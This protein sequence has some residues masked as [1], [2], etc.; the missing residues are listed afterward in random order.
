M[1]IGDKPPVGQSDIVRARARA[2]VAAAT[3]RAGSSAIQ[4]LTTVMGIPTAE[5]TP[6]V[7]AAILELMA[8]V[9]RL[10][11]ELSVALQRTDRLERLADEDPLVPVINRR[12][13]VREL[14]RAMSFAQRYQVPST[15]IFFDINGMKAVNDGLGHAA[16]D[17]VL[18]HV[19]GTLLAN[20]RKSD[21]VGRLGGDE[22]GVILSQLDETRAAAKAEQLVSAI[23]NPPLTWD[24]KEIVVQVAYGSYRFTGTEEPS[25]ALAAADQAMYAHKRSRTDP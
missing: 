22:F 24:G 8:E 21:I 5:L 17:S 1:K 4:D 14:S 9:D 23:N 2:G 3:G 19:A 7:Q 13:F 10:R 15:L 11:Q 16:G 12:A 6:K 20:V 25:A 18:K